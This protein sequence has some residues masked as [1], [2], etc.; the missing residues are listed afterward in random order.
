M[1][2]KMSAVFNGTW[3]FDGHGLNKDG[4]RVATMSNGVIKPYLEDS[5]SPTGMSP[6]RQYDYLGSQLQNF[7]NIAENFRIDY[8]GPAHPPEMVLYLKQDILRATP[9]TILRIGVT[10]EDGK[11]AKFQLLL[12]ASNGKVKATLM[13]YNDTGDVQKT[14]SARYSQEAK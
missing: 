9:D 2:D 7:C 1:S 10:R 8:V 12:A 13:A 14:V 3:S 6:N 5:T 11:V 4:G